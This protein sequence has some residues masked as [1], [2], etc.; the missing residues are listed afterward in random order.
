LTLTTANFPTVTHNPT[1]QNH[2]T[3]PPHGPTK[4]ANR[5]A[6]LKA[7]SRS[8]HFQH[9]GD[10]DLDNFRKEA[11]ER[12][13]AEALRKEEEE[14]A[15][16]QQIQ[17]MKEEVEEDLASLKKKS[18]KKKSEIRLC[19][20][21][22]LGSNYLFLILDLLKDGVN[23]NAMCKTSDLNSR[24]QQGEITPSNNAIGGIELDGLLEKGHLIIERWA[25]LHWA[26][27]SG[28]VEVIEILLKAGADPNLPSDP[29]NYTPLHISAMHNKP[30]AIFTLH[31]HGGNAAM[32]TSAQD[33]QS[34]PIHMAARSGHVEAIDALL[35]CGV[36]IDSTVSSGRTALLIAAANGRS[37]A[38][39]RLIQRGCDIL[40]APSEKGSLWALSRCTSPSRAARMISAL[41]AVILKG[42]TVLDLSDCGLF[43]IPNA[44][45]T[46]THLQ[47]LILRDNLFSTIP[48]LFFQMPSVQQID[49]R[50][51][52]LPL[53]VVKALYE[54]PQPFLQELQRGRPTKC[55]EMKLMIVGQENVGKSM[56]N[57]LG[58][59]L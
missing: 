44:L 23:P 7:L 17:A 29:F 41:K 30:Q 52:R 11:Q 5:R 8:T 15:L 32:M 28:D 3:L 55:G 58:V 20:Y 14:K 1:T 9:L 53:A 54:N 4:M 6:K 33:R 35:E 16:K 26:A 43:H 12:E 51:N 39:E 47:V 31:K 13:M 2:T 34:H 50:G 19:K 46:C 22:S 36:D 40:K 18:A 25:P 57:G 48:S 21:S 49:L 10:L 45:Q 42:K 37:A 56:Q 59:L 24:T 38:V 27:Y